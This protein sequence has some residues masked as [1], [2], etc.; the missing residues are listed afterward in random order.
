MGSVKAQTPP[1][2]DFKPAVPAQILETLLWRIPEIFM[3]HIH[4]SRNLITA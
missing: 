4:A 1:G 3:S 2:S